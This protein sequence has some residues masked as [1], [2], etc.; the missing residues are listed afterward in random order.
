MEDNNH[1][2][3]YT[4]AEIERLLTSIEGNTLGEIDIKH[5]FDM[6][7][8]GDKGIAGKIIEQSVLGRP[9][10]TKQH[11]DIVV[12]GKDTEIKTTGIVKVLKKGEI[13]YRA[14]RWR[15]YRGRLDL[16]S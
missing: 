8:S 1:G 3:E 10:D 5:L 12:D 4:K 16:W 14:T 2:R 6:N 11:P 13:S 7:A 9:V 15:D